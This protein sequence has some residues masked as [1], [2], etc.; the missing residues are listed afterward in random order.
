M[1]HEYVGRRYL[2]AV[3][4]KSNVALTFVTD[5]ETK[6]TRRVTLGVRIAMADGSSWFYHRRFHTW[7]RTLPG[8]PKFDRLGRVVS[9]GP[10]RK[11]RFGTTAE[12]KRA[13]G[14]CPNLIAALLNEVES[15]S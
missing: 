13:M 6:E 12:L 7:T 14:H 5:K 11:E 10:E 3:A 2:G 4:T 15:L 8:L 1:N 9:V